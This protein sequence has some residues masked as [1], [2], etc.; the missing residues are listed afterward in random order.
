M[1]VSRET[2]K[3]A[4]FAALIRKWNPRINLVAPATLGQIESRHIQDSVQLAE[5]AANARGGWLDIGSGG[6]LPGIVLAIC[7]PERSFTLADSDARKSVF[8]RTAARE[9]GL[10]NVMVLNDRIEALSPQQAS[11]I[12]A[13]A[14][15]PLPKLLA[16]ALPHLAPAGE[17]WL[18]KG[19]NWQ[20]EVAAAR[21]FF[22]FD[23]EPI[24][25]RTEE[26]AVILHITGLRN[27]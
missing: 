20:E 19:K 16:Y 15:A 11:H 2:D 27:A 14:L 5:A 8:L 21:D 24:E 25:S 18:M 10:T 12:S 1:S 9:L 3:L 6:G 4:Q 23:F 17:A 13:R 7:A 26:G 22:D